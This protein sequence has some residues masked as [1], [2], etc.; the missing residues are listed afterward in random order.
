MQSTPP[1]I[2]VVSILAA[3][4]F[5]R[6][7]R[8]VAT[9]QPNRGRAFLCASVAVA[10]LALNGIFG[11]VGMDMTAGQTVVSALAMAGMAGAGFFLVRAALRGEAAQL[12]QEAKRQAA[13]Y[14][15]ERDNDTPDKQ[16]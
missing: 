16:S 9:T 2:I 8:Q 1:V 13:R 10:V 14:R 3:L 11:Y 7:S 12:Q 6:M 4:W 15:Q 5:I